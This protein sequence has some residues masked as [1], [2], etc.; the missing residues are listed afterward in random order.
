[1]YCLKYHNGMLRLADWFL[2]RL[3]NK[4][5]LNLPYLCNNHNKLAHG[6]MCNESN[7]K[8]ARIAV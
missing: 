8:A 5:S 6:Q 2:D 3:N 1:M 4:G 7:R